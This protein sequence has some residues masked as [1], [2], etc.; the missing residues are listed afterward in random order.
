MSKDNNAAERG[1]DEF[2]PNTTTIDS[3]AANVDRAQGLV[4]SLKQQLTPYLTREAEHLER[5]LDVLERWAANAEQEGEEALAG[6]AVIVDTAQERADHLQNE[7]G[8]S[9]KSLAK[10]LEEIENTIEDIED[11]VDG[12]TI[13][14]TAYVTYVNRSFAA[15]YFNGDATIKSILI[16]GLEGDVENIESQVDEFGLFPQDGLFGESVED[17][18]FPANREVDLGA[19]NR[20]YWMSTSDGGKIA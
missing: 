8:Q 14:T 10:R 17:L 18:A 13:T 4:E 11:I 16:A 6:A 3:L 20:I 7:I 15:R 12:L 2:E 1:N 5:D 9:D 19:E